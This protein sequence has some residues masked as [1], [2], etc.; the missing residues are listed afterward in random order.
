MA[1]LRQILLITDGCS[2]TGEDP[3][4]MAALAKEQGITVNVV[5]VIDRDRL[6]DRARREIEGIADRGG[7]ISQI[8]YT[9]LLSRTVQMVT[10]QA[11][12]T[13]LQSVVSQELKQILGKETELDDLPPEKR[14]EILEVVEDLQETA[15]LEVV[16]LIDKSGSMESK[17][18][19]VKEALYDLSLS[20]GA[21]AGK[22]EYCLLAFPGKKETV[23]RILDWTPR[24]ESLSAGFSKITSGGLTP[25]GPAIREAIACFQNTGIWKRIGNDDSEYLEESI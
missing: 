3:L 18:P 1:T 10:R 20:L 21:R 7:G 17:L 11:M 6:D 9:R 13:T 5:G 4:A 23:E 19:T 15:D 24:I 16:I 14:G 8:V 25:T 2:N 12:T 22:N